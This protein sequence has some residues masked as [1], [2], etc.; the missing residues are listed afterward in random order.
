MRSWLILPVLALSVAGVFALGVNAPAD[1]APASADTRLAALQEPVTLTDACVWTPEAAAAG[2]PDPCAVETAAAKAIEA[3]KPSGK[4]LVWP[5][6][7]VELTAQ[8]VADVYE[9][10]ATLISDLYA[11]AFESEEAARKADS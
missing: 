2:T 6:D 8:A 7:F 4:A 10:A 3:T 1:G 5:D 11:F 9:A